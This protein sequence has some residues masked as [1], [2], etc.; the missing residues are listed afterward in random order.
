MIERVLSYFPAHT[1]P[2]TLVSDPDDVLADESI[3]NELAQRGFTILN[4]QD[5]IRLRHQLTSHDPFHP[6][7]PL[8]IVTPE[9]VNKLPYDLWQQAHHVTLALHTF[10]PHLNYPIVQQLTPQQRWQL[11]QQPAPAGKLGREATKAFILR[12]LFA[13]EPVALQTGPALVSWLNHYHTSIPEPL[14]PALAAY[15][16]T[17]LQANP[18]F[19]SWPLADLLADRAAFMDFV[20]G[21]WHHFL[22]QQTGGQL[23]EL[24]TPYLL[25]FESSPALQDT[26]PQLVRS[27]AL[28]PVVVSRPETLP[29]WATVAVLAPDENA[30]RR[31][32]DEL[33]QLLA[34]QAAELPAAR[35]AQ[36]QTVAHT[37][38]KLTRLC[39]APDGD[40]TRG[41]VGAY[42]LWQGKLDTTFLNWLQQYY[43][44]LAGMKLPQPHHLYHVSHYIAYRCRQSPASQRVALLILDGMALVDWLL[45]GEAWRRRRPGWHF[46]EQ[47][48]LAQLPTLTAISRQALV[49]GCRPVEF[50]DS[51]THNRQEQKLWAA[52]W[53]QQDRPASACVYAHLKLDQRDLPAELDSPRV[54]AL[55]L[56]VNAIDEIVHGAAL[57]TAD[58]QASLGVWLRHQSLRL[59]EVIDGLLQRGFAVYLTSD[60]GHVQAEGMGQPSQG[61]LV[62]TRSKRARLYTDRAQ[63]TLAQQAFSASCLWSGDGLLPDESWALLATGGSDRRLA[64]APAGAMVVSHGGPTLDEVVVPLVQIEHS[65]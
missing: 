49:S 40:L 18:A 7:R 21:Q 28:Q 38:A 35:W 37:W 3:R 8:I 1:H 19:A 10:F 45:I 17:Q 22:Q 30:A 14:P 34:T 54:E 58:V 64:F 11:S 43:A 42:R 4:E 61:V 63:A 31:Q 23:Y 20:A 6:D 56:V 50:V 62:S 59:E 57:G 12:H 25:P 52:F 27:G 16:L 60:H 55:C 26:V 46:T 5:P 41:Q 9:L 39:H 33:L 29:T 51:L 2:L 47:L 36:W 13:A 53:A 48:L 44:P 65:T 15:L 24:H 32:V